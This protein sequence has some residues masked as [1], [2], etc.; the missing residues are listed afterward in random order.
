M[1]KSF[2]GFDLVESI[3][4]AKAA[5]RFKTSHYIKMVICMLVSLF[6]ACMPSEWIPIEGLTIIEQRVMALF[7]FAASMWISEAMPAW[8]TSFLVIVIMLL[9]VSNAP[10]KCFAVGEV[11]GEY[12][13]PVNYKAIMAT[14]SDPT[15]MLFLGGFVLAIGMTK[16]KLDLYLA[17]VMLK[18][19]GC[20]SK[21]V[22]LGFIVVTAIFSAFVSNTATAAM[23]LT[24]LTPVL[25]AMGDDVKGRT[26]LALAIPLG[27][28]IGGIATPI[29][30]PPN[31]IALGYIS[32]TIGTPISFGSWILKMTPFVVFML[33]VGWFLLRFMFP[34]KQKEVHLEI[35]GEFQN[36]KDTFVVIGTF[37]VTV[38]LWCFGD[39][40]DLGL[41]SYIIALIPVASFITFGIFSRRDL[42][43]INWGVLWMVAGGFA[44]GLALNATHLSNHLVAS[45]PFGSWSFAVVIVA[46]V[47]LCYGLSNLISHSATAALLVPV[48]GVV[49]GSMADAT[50][51]ASIPLQMLV[52]VAV[53][54]SVAMILPISTPP[55]AIA[56]STGIIDQKDMMKV[57]VIL[58][59][60][61]LVCGVAWLL[62]IF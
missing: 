30:T 29:G 10:L 52:A 9:T 18:P 32:E 23:M 61:G 6:I 59:T 16:T 62:L 41:N 45:I 42:E 14:M 44:L 2:L 49:A 56:H 50:G 33:L 31:I 47:T 27:A 17:K 11:T 35:E 48:L 58:G 7:F 51:D 34:F 36:N 24:F 37:I 8:G 60:F 53:A 39:L 21:Y 40:L 54:S 26:A 12:G 22:L 1:F 3:H 38:F 43:E 4:L 55:N 13:Q 20:Q 15:I 19:F 25:K 57:G 46:A 28:N 5:K